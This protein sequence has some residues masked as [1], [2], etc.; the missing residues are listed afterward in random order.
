MQN[1][2]LKT[3]SGNRMGAVE[4]SCAEIKV[5]LISIKD[6]LGQLTSNQTEL[7]KLRERQQ[8]MADAFKFARKDTDK[9]FEI[10]RGFENI[11]A[12]YSG[13]NNYDYSCKIY[14][15]KSYNFLLW[16]PWK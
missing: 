14:F 1:E 11:R 8:N 5:E 15:V 4:I 6:I 16:S 13:G 12:E 9:M 10:L 7:L 3:D 2:W